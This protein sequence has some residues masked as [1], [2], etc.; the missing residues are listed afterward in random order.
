LPQAPKI[1]HASPVVPDDPPPTQPTHGPLVAARVLRGAPVSPGIARGT[2]YVLA[3]A[4]GTPV[5]RA[6]IAPDAVDAELARFHAALDRADG[7]LVALRKA[8]T[9]KI[10]ADQADIFA[11]HVLMVRDPAF[12]DRVT[13]LIRDKQLSAETA[14]SEVV[15][16]FSRTFEAIPDAYLRERAVDIRD[17]WRR[18]LRLLREDQGR[19]ALDIPA[20]AVVVADELMPSMTARMELGRV[21][22][23]VSEHGGKFSHTAI[24][25]RAQ[26]TPAV[27][28]IKDASLVIRTGDRVIVDAIAGAVFVN[29]SPTVEREYERVE[30]DMRA[31]HERLRGLVD[32][33][34]VTTDGTSIALLANVSKF[35]DTEAAL[36]VNAGG[37]GL[38][39]TEFGYA[40]RDTLPSEEEQFDYLNRAAA[41][42]HPRPVAL[43]LLDLGA[44][45]ALP[46]LPLS[47]ARN[48]ALAERGV[49]LLLRER[50][51]LDRQLRAFLRVSAEHPV[52]ILIPFVTAIEEVRAV[53]QALASA[54]R[55][56]AAE[57]RRFDER[58][59]LGAMIETP[60]AAIM[61]SSLARELD[62]FSL[63]TNDLVQY[64]LAADREDEQI[65]ANY[66]P[67][68]PAVLHLIAA[69]VAAGAAA[70]RP[71][72][73]CG[74]LAADPDC[75]ELLLGLGLRTLSVAP[76]K[77]LDVK[78]RIRT[79]AI[80][81]ARSLATRALAA[82]SAGEVAAMLAE[83]GARFAPL[84]N[85]P[86]V[87][88]NDPRERDPAT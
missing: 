53:R 48:P 88:L 60:S 15:E 68:H 59:P 49:R 81:E 24:L 27:A 34:A 52:S 65:A 63:G 19:D 75:T 79:V 82:G 38:Y 40:I 78:G 69:V 71:V 64:T 10:G 41:R 55:D 45:K 85:L 67:L 2:A 72:S 8:V 87:A 29:P 66:Q 74:D 7:E 57:G 62:F 33:P 28:G 61:A 14:L 25:A 36:M 83:R 23:L 47:A 44:D 12:H 21:S 39:R 17:V 1:K 50:A 3:C 80:A 58:V 77:L 56:L 22:A 37:I 5:P 51:I 73:I 76:G 31:V 32:L 18:V 84:P 11:A 46:Y 70:E 42:L 13:A 86:A 54:Q 26:G 16:T 20:A 30:K 9:D 4:T 43:R 6:T 35:A